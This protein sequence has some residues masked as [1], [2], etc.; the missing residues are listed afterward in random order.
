MRQLTLA[1]WLSGAV[2]VAAA[3]P[4]PWPYLVADYSGGKVALVEPDGKIAWEE[5]APS[6]CDVWL[7][8]GGNIL[9][10]WLRGA[11]EVTRDHTVVWQYQAAANEEVYGCQRLPNGDT[12]VGELG[13]CRAI[14]VAPD[15]R[16]IHK[17]V[18]LPA[19][20]DQHVRFRN[21]RKLANGHYLFVALNEAMVKELDGD[22][23][24]VWSAKA[25][26]NPF[27]AVRLANGNTL[28]GC[29]DGHAIQEFDAE[30][31]VVWQVG[32]F[33]PVWVDEQ[34]RES[35][36]PLRFVAGVERLPDGNTL[37]CNWLGHGYVGHGPHLL[38]ITPDKQVVWRN[39]D[40]AQFTAV[41]GVCVAG[42]ERAAR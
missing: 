38:L 15:G 17:E 18:R 8:P 12:L 35:V 39:D 26:G 27:C 22:G 40:H 14:E 10:A 5:R 31:K 11:K 13:A 16:T 4:A 33:E 28:V 3:Q 24:V 34:G 20:G 29:G 2:A 6:T 23:Q 32:E 9:F 25:L 7:L 19:T 42:V 21:L 41:S 37:V 1:V 30:G 36:V